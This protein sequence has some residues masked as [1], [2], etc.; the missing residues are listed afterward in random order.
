VI[1]GLVPI[2]VLLLAACQAAGQTPSGS[3][4]S[5]SAA[6]PSVSGAEPSPDDVPPPEPGQALT[7]EHGG[8]TV[9]LSSTDSAT[10]QL[11]SAWAWDLA[12]Q[13]GD[14]V[15]PVP[16][17]YA[18]DPGF[19]E[20]EIQPRGAGESVLTFAGNSN[21]GDTVVCPPREVEY[22]FIVTD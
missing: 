20:W 2:L 4:P 19:Y 8:A 22:R 21:C 17:N 10:I 9:E 15:D 3:G 11:S 12:D 14:A 18:A 5:Q 1:R 16:V 7:E 13:T 6:E